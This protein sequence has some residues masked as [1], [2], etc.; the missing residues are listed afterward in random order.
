MLRYVAILNTLIDSLAVLAPYLA[1]LAVALVAL[2]AWRRPRSRRR[3]PAAEARHA[4]SSKAWR[5]FEAQV[6]IGFRLQGYQL[7]ETSRGGA[8]RGGRLTLRRE[9]ETFLVECRHWRESRVGAEAVVAL[10]G[11]MSARGAGGGFIVTA[12]RFGRDAVGLASG[13]NIRLLDGNALRSLLDKAKAAKSM[14][15]GAA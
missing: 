11:A 10:Q 1:A 6:A 7:I 14:A 9:R 15:H 3:S 13:S 2:A 8:E 12:G 5:D 4:E